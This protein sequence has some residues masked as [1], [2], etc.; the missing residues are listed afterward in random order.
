MDFIELIGW[1]V[2]GWLIYQLVSAWVAI[3]H[4]K[5]A[6]T[7]AV[8]AQQEKEL[9]AKQ[10]KLIRFER[11]IQGSYD[12]VLAFGGDNKFILQGNNRAEVEQLLKEK[13]PNKTFHFV[14]DTVN[15]PNVNQR[16]VTSVAD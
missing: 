14:E 16:K 11:V 9:F 2:M 7:D 6:I 15:E 4:I 10:N 13:F 12:V 1:F 3:Q 8:N 5:H